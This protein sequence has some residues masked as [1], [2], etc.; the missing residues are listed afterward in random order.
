M[1]YKEISQKHKIY[2]REKAQKL[3][4]DQLEKMNSDYFISKRDDDFNVNDILDEDNY[5]YDEA[6]N[7]I[8]MRNN[9]KNSK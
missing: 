5:E 8:Q 3:T 1:N 9:F 2:E 7:F 6:S 4:W